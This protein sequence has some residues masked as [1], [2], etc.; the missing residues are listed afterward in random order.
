MSAQSIGFI[1]ELQVSNPAV[2]FNTGNT[3]AERPAVSRLS[4]TVLT[5][6]VASGATGNAQTA[7]D[8]LIVEH[9]PTVRYVARKIH[10][11]LPQHVDLEEL[12]SAG[13][14][15][16]IDAAAKFKQDKNAQ[17]KTYAQFRIRGAIM[18]SLRA[19]DWSP[20]ELRRKGRSAEE[21]IRS[22][23]QRLGRVPS[24]VEV[25]A[26]MGLSLQDYQK[27]LSDLKSL[28]VGSL[29]AERSAESDEEE[30]AYVAAPEDEDPLFRCLRAEMKQHLMDAID[31]LPERERMVL[32][33]YYYEELSMKEIAELLGVVESR[34]SQIR[35]SAV[36]HVRSA[37]AALA[38]PAENRKG[39][40]RS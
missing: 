4:G 27:L 26:E 5:S 17:F 24:E 1:S 12:V 36:L 2:F 33:L 7:A 16:L 6:G 10:E 37:M 20:R 30:L 15:G 39:T 25:A 35:S 9:L 18:D 28:E 3:R 40:V 34:I 31:S 22:S 14:V 11:G 19:M 21:A 32:T 23:T 13:I 38:Q 8:A 29:N